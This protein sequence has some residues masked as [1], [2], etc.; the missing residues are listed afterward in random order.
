VL[1]HERCEDQIETQ[2]LTCCQSSASTSSA[3][4]SERPASL[5]HRRQIE[6]GDVTRD[7]FT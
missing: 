6:A 5:D 3:L 1:K 4:G 2:S 7:P